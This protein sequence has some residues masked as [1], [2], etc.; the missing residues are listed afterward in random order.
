LTVPGTCVRVTGELIP[1]LKLKGEGALS[2]S[3]SKIT[4]DYKHDKV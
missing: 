4:A 2:G 3:T 1:G